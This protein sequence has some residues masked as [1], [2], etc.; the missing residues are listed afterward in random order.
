MD[1]AEVNSP[2]D[3]MYYITAM[4]TFKHTHLKTF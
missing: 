4:C 2:S 3:I 1:L